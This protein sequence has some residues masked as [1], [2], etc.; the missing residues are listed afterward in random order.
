MS[1][2]EWLAMLAVVACALAILPGTLGILML[3]NRLAADERGA[4]LIYRHSRIVLGFSAAAMVF[5]WLRAAAGDHISAV[6]IGSTVVYAGILAFGFLMHTRFLFQPVTNPKFISVQQA[7]DEFGPDEEVVGVFD[8][9]GEPWAFVARLAR[10]PHIVHQPHGGAPFMM[11]HCILSHSSMAYENS[12]AFAKPEIMIT[13]AIANNM[14]FYDTRNQCSVTQL[15][16][17]SRDGSLPLKTLPTLMMSLGTWA[18]LYPDTRVWVRQRTWRDTFYLKVLSRADVIDQASPVLVYPLMHAKDERLRLKELVLGVEVNGAERA[19]PLADLGSAVAINDELGSEPLLVLTAFG[20]DYAQVFS[21]RVGAS[22][23]LAFQRSERSDQS[24]QLVD[25]QTGSTWNL[26]GQCV[27]GQHQGAQ[28][29]PVPHYNKIFWF[30]WADYH[31]ATDVYQPQHAA[32]D[33]GRAA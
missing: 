9:A 3:T 31:P 11:T 28:L 10:R 22:T 8:P 7:L 15:H 2:A 5:A 18:Q 23:V 19:Y 1:G 4:R 30:A 13:A 12:G 21:R 20:G 24:D 33:R 16:N 27:E 32:A 25:T 6:V 29:Q 26:K 17:G 14:V